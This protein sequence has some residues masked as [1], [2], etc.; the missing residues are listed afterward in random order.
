MPPPLRQPKLL[1][2]KGRRLFDFA[3]AG[4]VGC[5]RQPLGPL[6]RRRHCLCLQKR[7]GGELRH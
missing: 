3:A 7:R 4:S 1:Q 2:S 6:A 5:E